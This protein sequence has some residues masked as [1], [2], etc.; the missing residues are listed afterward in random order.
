MFSMSLQIVA[1]NELRIL[2]NQAKYITEIV[3]MF[4]RFLVLLCIF[5]NVEEM[6][7]TWKWSIIGIPYPLRMYKA[8]AVRWIH[9]QGT[10]LVVEKFGNFPNPHKINVPHYHNLEHILHFLHLQ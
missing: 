4:L 8:F 9:V 10:I 2:K 1:N 6:D 3:T 5:P 7:Q